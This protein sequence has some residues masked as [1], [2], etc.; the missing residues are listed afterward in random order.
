MGQWRVSTVIVIIA[1]VSTDMDNMDMVMLV[2]VIKDKLF[3][4]ASI[5]IMKINNSD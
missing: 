1:S 2:E 4:G 3:I 5:Q